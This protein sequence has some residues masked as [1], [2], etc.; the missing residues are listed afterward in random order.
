M[1]KSTNVAK[2]NYIKQAWY[3]NQEC[4]II[5]RIVPHDE[6]LILVSIPSV[7][8]SKQEMFKDN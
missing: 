2:N 1:K 3:I 8:L 6:N 5:Q 4:V 7:F